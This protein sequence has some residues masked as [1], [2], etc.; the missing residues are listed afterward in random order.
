MLT[1][2]FKNKTKQNKTKQIITQKLL[3]LKKTFTDH[4]HDKYITT[5]EFNR[6]LTEVFDEILKQG[7][8]VTKTDLDDKLKTQI[9]TNDLNKTKHLLVENEFKKLQTYDSIILEAKV[10]LKKMVH[11]IIQYSSQYT[12]IL[13]GLQVSV[14]VIM[15]IFGNRK[16]CLVKILQL[17]LQLI[18]ALIH[19]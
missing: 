16:D 3:T 12:D 14:V 15:F 18:I 19:N 7:N 13:K 8:L 6:F 4:N 5:P 9:K 2:Q 11:K 1:V 10:I 17:L